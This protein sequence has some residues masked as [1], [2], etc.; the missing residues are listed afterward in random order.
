[1]TS[2]FSWQN[3]IS[4]CFASFWMKVKEWSKKAGLKLSIQKM[5]IM[6]SGPITSQQLDGETVKTVNRLYFRL[7]N[8]CGW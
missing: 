5:K 1:M 6:A 8:H 3:S 7:Q 2:A 4:L